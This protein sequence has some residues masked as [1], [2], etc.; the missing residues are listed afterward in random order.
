MIGKILKVIVDDVGEKHSVGRTEYDSPEVD[1][2]VNINDVLNIGQ[3]YNV[4]IDSANEFEL[5]GTPV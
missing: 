3:F 4:K 1:N 5:I 2:I